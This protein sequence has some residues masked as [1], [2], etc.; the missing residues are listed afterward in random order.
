MTISK[1]TSAFM[2]SWVCAF[3]LLGCQ[4][5]KEKEPE[6]TPR[7]SSQILMDGKPWNQTL[8]NG[9]VVATRTVC[10]SCW[11]APLDTLYK[12][13]F[14]LSISHFYDLEE[15]KKYPFESIYLG[16]IPI[17]TGEYKF[18]EVYKPPCRLNTIPQAIF[19]TS[20]FDTGKDTYHILP[21]ERQ[22][23]RVTKVDKAKGYVEGE[24]MMT[25]IRVAKTKDSTSPDTLRI[26]PSRFSAFIGA[27]D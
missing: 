3:C 14:T 24:F 15:Y 13:Y 12:N 5:E 1:I 10:A 21:S 23:I 17:R 8:P 11:M 7:N 19:F 22:Y 2:L 9:V 27:N 20:E 4:K 16:A 6:P 26:Q 18:A 25:F